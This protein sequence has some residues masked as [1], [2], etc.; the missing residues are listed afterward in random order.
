MSSQAASAASPAKHSWSGDLWGGLGSMLVALPSA[1]AFGVLVFTAIGP[2]HA[3]AGAMAG[4][5]G[6]ATLG[7]VAP[8]V[9]RNGGFITAPCAPAA[10][11][12][13][14]FAAHLAVDAGLP[15]GRVVALMAIAAL[16]SAGLQIGFG[17]LRLGRFMKYIPYQV[18]SGYLSGVAVI[19]AAGQ[20]PK[21]LGV[22]AGLGFFEGLTSPH[23]WRWPGMVVG[24]ATILVTVL[25]PR[26]T[27]RVPAAI[28]GLAA[29]IA[30]YFAIS[31]VRPD[32]LE[33][34]G[35][36]L[37]IGPIDASG[38]V[39]DVVGQA[40]TSLTQVQ[41]SDLQLVLA[42]AATLSVLL[43][44]DTLKTGVVLDVLT[45]R[46]HNSNRELIA[47]GAGNAVAALT[48]GMPG[49]G[50]MGPTLVNVTSGGRSPWSGVAE[51]V[52]AALA[53]L[54]L[55]SAIAWV[56][57]GAL[58]GILLVVAFRMFDWKLFRLLLRRGTR[59]DFVVIV[60]VIVVAKGVGLIQ[61]SVVGI[62]LA[63]LLF[64]R[65]QMR[66]SV[67]VAK[68][69]L[70]QVASKTAR[71][72]EVRK[73]LDEHGR[74][75]VLVELQDDLF[76]GT[77]DQVLSDLMEDL[78]TRRFVL[79]DLRRVQS[80]DY[81]AAQLFRQMI[82]RLEER[83][84]RLLLSGMPSTSGNQQ[85]F[86]RYLKH[87]GLLETGH[88]IAIHETRNDALEWMED[89]ILESLGHEDHP[90]DPPLELRDLELFRE[91]D[92]EALAELGEIAEPVTLEAGDKVFSQGDGGDEL[93]LVRRGAIDILLPLP[94][95]KRHH[96]ATVARGDYFG[97]MAFLDRDIRS[98]DA[99]ARVHSELFVL[100]RRRFNEVALADAVV[101]TKV[102]ARLALL[103]SRRLRMANAELSALEER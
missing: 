29:G 24:V 87:V 57:I 15:A 46:R 77:T 31:T 97:E 88:E 11:V 21:F 23:H 60:S 55:R 89:Q 59:L 10:A 18:V 45:R 73:M 100:S 19:I 95:G 40:A 17:L 37:I 80:M 35:N 101:A 98:A 71:L 49:A 16:L 65:A 50:T 27:T 93:Y 103:V 86:E 7:L 9:G 56:P 99:V 70:T 3:G 94:E 85:D 62:A 42:T 32:L 74:D 2:E 13:S 96:V 52:F 53:F 76:F 51:G 72:S 69:D 92:D 34:T 12:M 30:T 54:A 14:G 64:I 25:A 48:G 79:L 68:R 33:V 38:S 26:V 36:S 90:E 39:L 84:G 78:Q 66:G 22:P 1:I 47:Q 63:I 44:I 67:I 28:L 91:F 8:L 20:I 83:D 81:T 75:G 61:A 6:A 43:S 41:L 5:L 58:A 4:A 82:E 102:F